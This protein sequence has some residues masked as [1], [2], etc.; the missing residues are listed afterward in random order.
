MSATAESTRYTSFPRFPLYAI[1]ALLALSVISVS[2]VRVGDF[3]DSYVSTAAPTSER[4]LRFTDRADGSIA[5]TDGSDGSLVDVVAPGTN[6]FLRGAL[7]GLARERRRSSIGAEPPFI[8]TAR[9]DGRLTLDDPAT[10]RQVDLKSFGVT[11]AGVF[12][13]LLTKRNRPAVVGLNK[14]AIQQLPREAN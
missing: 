6:G 11:N 7:R 8:L 9:L 10:N 2:I 14:S 1:G 3:S 13:A 5:I 4:A 12:E